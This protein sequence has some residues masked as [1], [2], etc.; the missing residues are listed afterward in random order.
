[1][2]EAT[3]LSSEGILRL[4][5]FGER[6]ALDHGFLLEGDHTLEPTTPILTRIWYLV[7]IVIVVIIAVWLQESIDIMHITGLTQAFQEGINIEVEELVLLVELLALG[8][9]LGLFHNMH[10]F[11]RVLIDSCKS[12]NC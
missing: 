12:S 8:L 3:E 11:T 7:I 5:V 10:G 2:H 6:S 1:M 9:E 4:H